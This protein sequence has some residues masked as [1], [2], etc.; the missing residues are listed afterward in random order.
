MYAGFVLWIVGWV[1]GNGAIA[2]SI[3]AM[4]CVGN[5]LHWRHLEE[6]AMESRYGEDY[7]AYRETTWF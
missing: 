1:V 7:R 5:I 3:V 4:L 6:E 2:S